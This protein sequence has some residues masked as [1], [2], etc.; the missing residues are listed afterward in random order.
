MNTTRHCVF[1]VSAKCCKLSYI[2]VDENS[3]YSMY[4]K[5]TQI[6]NR[7][8]IIY[9]CQYNSY[10][11]LCRQYFISAIKSLYGTANDP[12]TTAP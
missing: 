12:S 11:T 1:W 9:Y 5:Y 6:S 2:Q 10:P 3:K 8:S 4:N 7:Y